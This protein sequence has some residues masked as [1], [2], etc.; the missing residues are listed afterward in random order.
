[1]HPAWLAT[2]ERAAPAPQ[3]VLQDTRTV[4]LWLGANVMLEYSLEEARS[5]APLCVPRPMPRPP[6]PMR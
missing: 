5:V 2:A 1:L 4:C 6:A 3:A